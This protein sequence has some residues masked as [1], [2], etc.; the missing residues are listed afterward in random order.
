MKPDAQAVREF[1]LEHYEYRDGVFYWVKMT[2]GCKSNLLGE[3]AGVDDKTNRRWRQYILGHL[4]QRGML[5]WMMHHGSWPDK[6]LFRID[7]DTYNDRIENLQPLR[8]LRGKTH[9][10]LQALRERRKTEIQAELEGI[11]RLHRRGLWRVDIP[12][13]L[14][15]FH[16][17][18]KSAV[19]AR[20]AA[21]R[22]QSTAI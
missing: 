14:P 12:G 2:E 6:A 3:V 15:S 21:L 7:G 19:A 20:E 5:V 9:P 11:T 13:A 17:D 10:D 22:A 4:I 18:I 16:N 1:V 8:R